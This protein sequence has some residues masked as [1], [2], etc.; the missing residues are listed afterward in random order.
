M[1]SRT[2][3]SPVSPSSGASELFPGIPHVMHFIWIQGQD[4]VPNKYTHNMQSW[5][6]YNPSFQIVVH[7]GKEIEELLGAHF[8]GLLK[9]YHGRNTFQNK[10]DIGQFM[11]LYEYGGVFS[12]MDFQCVRS[13][14]EELADGNTLLAV[15]H[16]A[17]NGLGSTAPKPSLQFFGSIPRHPVIAE[18]MHRMQNEMSRKLPK[19]TFGYAQVIS[20]LWAQVF[21]E[22]QIQYATT[23]HRYA[24]FPSW[25]VNLDNPFKFFRLGMHPE[26]GIAYMTGLQG[27]WHA[28]FQKLYHTA[29]WAYNTHTRAINLAAF[30]L[31][32]MFIGINSFL[33][34]ALLAKVDKLKTQ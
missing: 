9:A 26:R 10:K 24:L 22:L 30:L 13:G 23:P 25:L 2:L 29:V 16:T 31:L 11:I 3:P 12:D 14:L 20:T 32:V 21:R 1:E 6:R 8:P 28:R 18:M 19:S 34:I 15:Q 4:Q 33:L 7:D 5:Q 27:S 17:D